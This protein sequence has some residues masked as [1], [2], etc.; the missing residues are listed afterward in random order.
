MEIK[1]LPLGEYQAN[2][3]VVTDDATKQAV[4]FDPGVPSDEVDDALLGYELKYIFLTHGHFDH[5]YGC[6]DLK[7]KNPQA[8]ICIHKKDEI[9]L[10]NPDRNL[11]GDF[12]GYLPHLEAD[13]VFENGDKF[14]ACSTEYEVLHTP[15]HSE[16]SSCFIDKANKLIFSGDTLFCLT[17][18]RTDFLGGNFDDMM[19]SLKALKEYDED[20]VVYPGHNRSTTIGFEQKRNRYMRKL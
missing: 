19:N 18:G 8:K 1:T 12:S 14:S 20:Y 4:V 16:G 3:Y 5:I 15:G 11:V 13:V 6:A 17:C 7:E 2:C 9:C 10:N